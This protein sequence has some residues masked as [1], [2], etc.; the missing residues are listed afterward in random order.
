MYFGGNAEEGLAVLLHLLGW[1]ICDASPSQTREASIGYATSSTNTKPL[2]G[3]H[4]T[5]RP[6]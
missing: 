4:S 1:M 5:Q 6:G 3:S 2:T